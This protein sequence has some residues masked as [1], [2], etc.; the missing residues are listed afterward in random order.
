MHPLDPRIKYMEEEREWFASVAAKRAVDAQVIH[1]WPLFDG[2]V[3]ALPR[4][5]ESRGKYRTKR[6]KEKPDRSN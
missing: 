3:S 1:P 4:A 2:G 6:K 5:A